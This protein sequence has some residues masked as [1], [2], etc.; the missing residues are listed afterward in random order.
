M[1]MT[2]MATMTKTIYSQ[3]LEAEGQG[4]DEVGVS[5]SLLAAAFVASPSEA[6]PEAAWFLLEDL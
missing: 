4:K 5:R 2:M 1:M 6:E 3:K